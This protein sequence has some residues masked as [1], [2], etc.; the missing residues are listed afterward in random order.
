MAA[1]LGL[2][3]SLQ[4]VAQRPDGPPPPPPCDKDGQEIPPPPPAKIERLKAEL[5]L[6]DEQATQLEELHTAHRA[7]IKALR[8]A[9][10]HPD[11]EQMKALRKQHK[12]AMADI[13]TEEQLAKMKEMR[14]QRKSQAK[15]MKRQHKQAFNEEVLPLLQKQ[16]AKFEDMLSAQHKQEIDGLRGELA[17]LKPQF[18]ALRQ[19]KKQQRVEQSGPSEE[20]KAQFKA[21]REEK[22]TIMVQA[23]Q[24]AQA[25]ESELKSL[26]EEIKP[27]LEAFHARMKEQHQGFEGQNGENPKCETKNGDCK[28]GRKAQ[29]AI[30]GQGKRHKKGKGHHHRQGEEGE[31]HANGTKGDFEG[32]HR[33]RK[34]AQF[35]LMTPNGN[36]EELDGSLETPEM[37]IFPNPSTSNNT[38]TYTLRTAGNVSIDLLNKEGQVLKTVF[39]GKQEAGSHSQQVD[40]QALGMDIY[41]YRVTTPDDVIM[42]RF[43][44]VKQ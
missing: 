5:D 42:K 32:K 16:R 33:M 44:V 19:A 22:K 37:E 15:Q 21:L 23:A 41:Y 1:C 18:Q 29:G 14:H 10:D 34:A 4:V 26:H 9:G 36:M 43:T 6:T 17:E 3:F 20:L 8:Q 11:H 40:T 30:E 12:A 39:S 31:H 35:V 13:L 28:K 38:L 7:D 27:E 24:I 2:V 25:Y